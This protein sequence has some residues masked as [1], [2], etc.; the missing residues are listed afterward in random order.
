MD[1][2][3]I[4]TIISGVFSIAAALGSIVLKDHLDRLRAQESVSP[5]ARVENPYESPQVPTTPIKPRHAQPPAKPTYLSSRVL[6]IPIST[7][8]V[9]AIV[10]MVSRLF[11][12]YAN[13]GG[14]HYESLT[15]FAILT[16]SCLVLVIHN[17]NGQGFLGHLLYQLENLALWSGFACGWSLIH[18]YFWGDLVGVSIAWWVCCSVFGSVVL[19]VFQWRRRVTVAI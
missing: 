13:V 3:I 17:R 6:L 12:P 14:T 2:Q 8:V 11:R 18:G 1:A 10:G 15:A 7:V 16:V 9:G 5:A 19:A 4:S